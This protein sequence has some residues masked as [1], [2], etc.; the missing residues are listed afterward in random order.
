[1][2]NLILASAFMFYGVV[3]HAQGETLTAH[4]LP[5]MEQTTRKHFILELGYI[6]ATTSDDTSGSN[7][8][9]GFSGGFLFDFLGAGY[10]NLETGIFVSQQGFS[11]G[12]TGV[13]KV[14]G[15]DISALQNQTVVGKLTYVAI[16]ILAKINLAGRPLNT[17]F[18]IAGVSPQY[19]LSND[20]SIE[21][22]DST[23]KTLSYS[24]DMHDYDP[25][26]YDVTGVIGFGGSFRYSDATSLLLQATY[27]RGF[28][29]IGNTDSKFYN[30]SIL[31]TLG[32]GV[33]L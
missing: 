7:I 24:A 33:D 21:G 16:P 9:H 23:G 12:T 10:L 8:Q 27:N 29:P 6:G 1:M 31:F 18:I 22:T 32:F 30:Q 4:Q 2:K 3:A 19:L 26:M 28:I 11:Y 14:S 20:I 15:T 25:P 17:P 5:I 13:T